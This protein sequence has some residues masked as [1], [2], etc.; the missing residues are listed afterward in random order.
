MKAILTGLI[1]FFFTVGYS[2]TI[3][4]E[5]K[6]TRIND[7]GIGKENFKITFKDGYITLLDKDYNTSFT[8]NYILERKEY[9]YDDESYFYEVYRVNN[10]AVLAN[11]DKVRKNN[12]AY[13]FLYD[14]KGG[15][16]IRVAEYKIDWEG[17]ITVKYYYTDYFSDVLE[18]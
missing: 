14:K 13:S 1:L 5:T 11:P 16:V 2:Q 18:K 9:G 12:R 10:D 4:V 3:I 7:S 17:D 8:Y 15:K 6:Y